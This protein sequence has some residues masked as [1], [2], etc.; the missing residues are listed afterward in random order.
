MTSTR[1]PRTQAVSRTIALV[2][3]LTLAPLIAWDVA[4]QAFP[5]RAHDALAAIP[6]ALIAV[7]CL[8]HPIVRRA[9]RLEIAKAAMLAAAFLFWAANQWLP[10]H[11]LSTVF[12]DIA[13]ALFVIDVFLAIFGWPDT[14]TQEPAPQPTEKASTDRVSGPSGGPEA[15]PE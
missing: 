3:V 4:P 7:A 15:V 1:P 11:P 8:A 14:G 5:A 12:N 10:E 6:L 9:H 2:T 13:V